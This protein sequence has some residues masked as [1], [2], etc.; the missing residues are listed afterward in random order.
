[1]PDVELCACGKPLHYND[2]QAEAYVR[3]MVAEHGECVRI[4]T[5]SGIWLVPRHYIALHGIRAKELPYL[6]FERVDGEEN[7][8]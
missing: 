2:P 6:G 8:K 7:T 3:R 5:V 1:M 4:Q